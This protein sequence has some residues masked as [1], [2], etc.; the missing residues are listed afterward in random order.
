MEVVAGSVHYLAGESTAIAAALDGWPALPTSRRPRATGDN[1][2]ARTLVQNVE[3]LTRVALVA[4]G[5]EGP[6]VSLLTVIGPRDRQV[7]QV[8]HGMRFRDVLAMT[9]ALRAGPPQA[10][11][12]GGFGGTWARW[13][14]VE[15][16]AVEEFAVRRAGLS[17]G[18]GVVAPVWPGAC[19]VAEAAA[20]ATYLAAMSA[21]QCGPCMFGLPALAD[22][23]RR[24][25]LGLGPRRNRGR[26]DD[27]L[28]AV[29][30]RGACHH[31]DGATG[32]I[33]SAITAF[34]ADVEATGAV[35]R[36][37]E[38]VGSPFPC[39]TWPGDRAAAGVAAAGRP[40]RLPGGRLVR[41]RSGPRR[42]PRPVGLPDPRRR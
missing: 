10:V 32:M 22:D 7:L 33:A 38:Q 15:G 36:A 31:P 34:S 17:L 9:G 16:L 2:P 14:Q 41:P 27:L 29:A 1:G 5:L 23:L 39:R 21:R 20:V 26:L 8:P 42:R 35:D 3:T 28:G 19:G 4:R 11:L 30:G 12:L 6:Q 37:S 24:L 25:A 40:D 13:S 18:A